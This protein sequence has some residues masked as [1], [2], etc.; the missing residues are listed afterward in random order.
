GRAGPTAITRSLAILRRSV[1]LCVLSVCS[2]SLCVRRWYLILGAFGRCLTKRSRAS[3]SLTRA[4]PRHRVAAAGAARYSFRAYEWRG[5]LPPFKP[6]VH[7]QS[8]PRPT[9]P[10]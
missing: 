1:L 6:I 5:Y 9:A 4:H 10:L 7:Q 8:D 2:V 3:L